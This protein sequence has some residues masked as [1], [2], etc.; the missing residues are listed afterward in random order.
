MKHQGALPT[1]R[2]HPDPIATGSVEA[3]DRACRVCGQR[4]KYIYT[5]PVHPVEELDGAICPWCIADGSAYAR[6]GAEFTDLKGV[7]G[8]N[9]AWDPVPRDVAEEVAYRTPGFF[10]WQSPS[11]W[12]QRRCRGVTRSCGS[13]GPDHQVER[14][15]GR[16]PQGGGAGLSFG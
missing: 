15:R 4:R 9:D 2:Y 5:G 7:G 10:T 16:D 8:N 3:L 1:F 13:R 6:F 11:W 14:G 12:T